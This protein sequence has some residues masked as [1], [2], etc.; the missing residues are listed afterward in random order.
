MA[1]ATILPVAII[2]GLMHLSNA[3]ATLLGAMNTAVWGVLFGYA[4]YKTSALWLPIGI[5]FGWN[6]MQPLT[7]ANLSGFTMRVT[8]YALHQHAG[9]WLSGG[10]YGPEGSVLATAAAVVLFWKVARLHR[11]GA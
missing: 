5:H 10:A 2:F 1:F 8:G 3:N 11:E 6:V 7:G 4:C 9:P